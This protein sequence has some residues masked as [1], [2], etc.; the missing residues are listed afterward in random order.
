MGGT[1]LPHLAA[2][3]GPGR[4]LRE[5]LGRLWPSRVGGAGFKGEFAALVCVRFEGVEWTERFKGFE[6][7]EGFERLASEHQRRQSGSLAHVPPRA[8]QILRP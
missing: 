2:A 8:L 5:L 4:N 1:D 7:I 6:R 3:D